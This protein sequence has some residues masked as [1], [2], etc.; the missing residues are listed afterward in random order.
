MMP[1]HERPHRTSTAHT[2]TLQSDQPQV[3]RGSGRSLRRLLGDRFPVPT[4]ELE[5]GQRMPSMECARCDGT[6]YVR[7]DDGDIP[8][9]CTRCEGTGVVFVEEELAGD[10]IADGAG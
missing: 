4:S 7:E 2:S 6:G 8:S 9:I 5:G 1:R 10:A 3:A